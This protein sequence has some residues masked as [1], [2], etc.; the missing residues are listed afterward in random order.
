[1]PKIDNPMI[2]AAANR[3]HWHNIGQVELA[4]GLSFLFFR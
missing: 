4:N 2:D 1:M 3:R